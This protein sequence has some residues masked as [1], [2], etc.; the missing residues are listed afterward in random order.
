MGDCLRTGGAL[1]AAILGVLFLCAENVYGNAKGN[2]LAEEPV[3]VGG[4]DLR[5]CNIAVVWGLSDG[6]GLS[7]RVGPGGNRRKVGTLLNGSRVRICNERRPWLGIFYSRTGALC[8]LDLMNRASPGSCRS[9]WVHRRW[10][11]VISG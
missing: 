2:A 4:F 8:D 7:I 1:L 9:G 11:T 6:S 3:L 5:S 10:V